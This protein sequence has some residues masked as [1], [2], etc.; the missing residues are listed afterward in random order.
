MSNETNL[1]KGGK[2][3]PLNTYGLSKVWLKLY[4]VDLR[5]LDITN[6]KKSIKSWLYAD[7]LFKPEEMTMVRPA[8]YGGLGVHDIKHKA[9]AGLIRSFLET[10]C[11]TEIRQS[12]FHEIL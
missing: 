7:M 2:L 12:L 10:V 9:L 11:N 8:Q 4:S 6:I 1:L 3:L 5:V